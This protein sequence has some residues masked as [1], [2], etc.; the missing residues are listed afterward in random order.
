MISVAGASL[1]GPERSK[2]ALEYGADFWYLLQD[3]LF[4]IVGNLCPN[5]E[6]AD[7]HPNEEFGLDLVLVTA[8]G[9]GTVLVA[10]CSIFSW[11]IFSMT[12]FAMLWMHSVTSM[13]AFNHIILITGLY[14]LMQERHRK[15]LWD[16]AEIIHKTTKK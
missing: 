13:T 6:T 7:T 4:I 14:K 5:S 12:F 16:L 2:G 9:I 15:G 1:L 10:T 8:V 11:P 3:P